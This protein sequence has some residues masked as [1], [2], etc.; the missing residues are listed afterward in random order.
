MKFTSW[1]IQNG[2]PLESFMSFRIGVK[3]LQMA[4]LLTELL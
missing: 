1:T 3:P 2:V 4:S